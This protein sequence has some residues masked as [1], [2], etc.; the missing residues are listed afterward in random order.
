MTTILDVPEDVSLHT[1]AP[2]LSIPVELVPTGTPPYN[3]EPLASTAAIRNF[4]AVLG[5]YCKKYH[6]PWVFGMVALILTL[7][8]NAL[9]TGDIRWLWRKIKGD[10]D[11][12]RVQFEVTTG[13][14]AGRRIIIGFDHDSKCLEVVDAH[15][16]RRELLVGAGEHGVFED[17][18]YHLL[19]TV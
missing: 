2:H 19:H 13:K 9:V 10:F 1:M 12:K 3:W 17:Y 5:G 11:N 15:T 14:N 4:H 16:N 18:L 8:W 7:L 6:E